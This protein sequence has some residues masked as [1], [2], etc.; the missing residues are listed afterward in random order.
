MPTATPTGSSAPSGCWATDVLFAEFFA[1][2]GGLSAEVAKA[3]APTWKPDDLESG[4]ID[5][6]CGEAV[7]ELKARLQEWKH[8]GAHLVLHFA[9]PCATFSRARDRSRL[10]RLRSPQH[11]AGLPGVGAE[12]EAANRVA[13]LTK[14]LA[15]WAAEELNA[16]ITIENPETSYLWDYWGGWL[17]EGRRGDRRRFLAMHVRGTLQKE[18]QAAVLQQGKGGQVSD[19]LLFLI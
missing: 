2:E 13:D 18:H 17:D 5:F 10:T 19:Y 11:V 7:R 12:V 14:D 1:G 16:I 3:G 8:A 4:G 15:E 9:P 6:A